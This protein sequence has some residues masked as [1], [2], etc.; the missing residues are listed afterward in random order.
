M[1]MPELT[2]LSKSR[3][4]ASSLNGF[5]VSLSASAGAVRRVMATQ[6]NDAAPRQSFALVN[7]LAIFCLGS[8]AFLEVLG[9]VERSILRIESRY[10]FGLRGIDCQMR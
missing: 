7:W 9:S 5:D 4:L 2:T 6:S 3:F 1:H 10:G 8:P